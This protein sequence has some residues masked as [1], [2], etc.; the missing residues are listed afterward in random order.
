MISLDSHQQIQPNIKKMSNHINPK[1]CKNTR[2]DFEPKSTLL[3]GSRKPQLGY[4]TSSIFKELVAN[5]PL[6]QFSPSAPDGYPHQDHL[7]CTPLTTNP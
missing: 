3:M 6:P 5:D 2:I 1:F 7:V 4:F